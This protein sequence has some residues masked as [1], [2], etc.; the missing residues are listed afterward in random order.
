MTIVTNYIITEFGLFDKFNMFD[1][2]KTDSSVKRKS[3]FRKQNDNF[4]KAWSTT[5]IGM[6]HLFNRRKQRSFAP[7]TLV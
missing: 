6:D 7:C 5:V 1:K 2:F 4:K 3:H